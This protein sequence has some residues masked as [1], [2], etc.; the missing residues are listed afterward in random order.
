M[1]GP[2]K[3]DFSQV[4]E[5]DLIPEG[6]YNAIVTAQ[7]VRESQS[8]EYPYINWT[9]TINGG[10][11]DN[12]KLWTMTSLSP[13]A[14]FR[15]KEM[16]VALGE[17]KEDLTG[18]FELDPEK[19]VGKGVIIQ[20]IHEKYEGTM[21]ERVKNVYLE[22]STSVGPKGAAGK[23]PAAAGSTATKARRL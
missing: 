5:F 7:E 18:D 17:K 14:A 6:N 2:L 23:A 4:Q 19:Y 22:G 3:I 15:L 16:L 13:K 12:R 1:T 8:S 20:V 10:E 9:L 21:R 11:H